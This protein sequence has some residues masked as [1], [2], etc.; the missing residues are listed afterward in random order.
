MLTPKG[1]PAPGVDRAAQAGPE[2]ALL[3][4]DPVVRERSL[5]VAV[6][7]AAVREDGGGVAQVPVEDAA[8]PPPPPSSPRVAGTSSSSCR[9]GGGHELLVQEQ[10]FGRVAGQDQLG[11]EDDGGA[12]AA[13]LVEAGGDLS[14]VLLER[15]HG[16]VD[17]GQ[18]EADGGHRF[19]LAAR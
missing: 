17:L 3:V 15:P 18:G 6:D 9:A 12:E 5:G 14:P 16:G 11:K 7:P 4:E 1:G 8:A 2:V 13:G 10:V 19:L